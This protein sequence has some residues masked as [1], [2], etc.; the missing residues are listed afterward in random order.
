MACTLVLGSGAR[1]HAL[2]W[3]CLGRAGSGPVVA[4][5]GNPGMAQAGIETQPLDLTDLEAVC[6]LADQLRPDLVVVG[7]EAPLVAGVADHLRHLGHAVLGPSAA[8]ARLEGSKAFAKGVMAAAGVP[9]AGF[10]MAASRSE[11]WAAID[12]FGG[13][14]A[15]KA[16]GLAQGKGVY[17]AANAQEARSVGEGWLTRFGRLVVEERLGGPE[18]SVQA[19]VSGDDVVALPLARDY[20]RRFDGDRGPNTGGMGAMAPVVCSY[21]AETLVELAIRPVAQQMSRMGM[22]LCGVLYAGLMLTAEGPRVLEY[23]VR[24]GDPETQVLMPLLPADFP[25]WMAA[26]ALGT[27]SGV[28]DLPLASG[29]AVGVVVVASTYPEGEAEPEAIELGAPLPPGLLFWGG[30]SGEPGRLLSGSGRVAT[31]VGTG[32]SRESARQAAY[33]LAASLRFPGAACRSDVGAS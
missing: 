30:V 18:L 6:R 10:E 25:D 5:P 29:E 19:L 15:L 14:V 9:T 24:L 4:A 3:R 2:A 17:V 26:A 11:L 31:A 27:L 28:G 8:A 7:P 23:N 16:D 22:P 13:Q 12:R 33:R 20:K 32:A 21:P 1:E